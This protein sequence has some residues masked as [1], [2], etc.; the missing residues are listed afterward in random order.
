MKNTSKRLLLSFIIS[1]SAINATAARGG[2][3]VGNGGGVV[4]NNFIYAYKMLPQLL[5]TCIEKES[6]YQN[7]EDREVFKK[8]KSA[9]E[10]NLRKSTQDVFDFTSGKNKQGFF[11]TGASEPH[12]VAKTCLSTNC[13][14]F[15][16]VDLL[17][18]NSK[19]NLTYPAIA[20]LL[21]HEFGHQAGIESHIYLDSLGAKIRILADSR[22]TNYVYPYDFNQIEV[23]QINSD[24]P[25]KFAEL[26]FVW[27]GK[28]T[29]LTDKIFSAVS[30]TPEF[31]GYEL[32][33][34]HYLFENSAGIYVQ[35]EIMAKVYSGGESTAKVNLKRFRVDVSSTGDILSFEMLSK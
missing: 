13:P 1:V 18:Q 9:V 11:V 28:T 35:F 20:G 24:F 3:V 32:F 22:F 5:S 16:N 2:D 19:I 7:A 8:I 29:R 12:R 34:G 10:I 25:M 30:K 15:I 33:N 26:H 17:Y 23:R 31:I 27:N 4:E 6:C 14:V 21:V